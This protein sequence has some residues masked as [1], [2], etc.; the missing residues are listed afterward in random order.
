MKQLR[1]LLTAVL[2]I[3]L[4]PCV[5]MAKGTE[6]Y[7]WKDK[8][9]DWMFVLMIGTNRIKSEKEVKESQNQYKSTTEVRKALGARAVGAQ[10]FWIDLNGFAYPPKALRREIEKAAKEASIDLHY[11]SRE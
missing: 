5:S 6:L 2:T 10:V 9:G 4:L 7:S 11:S 1:Y 3:T 8:K